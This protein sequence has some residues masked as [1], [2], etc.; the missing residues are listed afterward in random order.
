MKNNAFTLAE[1]LIVIGIIGV[2]A[3]LTL[4]NLNHATGDKEKVTK[5]KK[6]YSA[7]A[8]AV[9]RA[10][11]IYGDC[12]TWYNT[13]SN[14]VGEDFDGADYEEGIAKRITE[15][16]KVSKICGYEQGCWSD[17]LFL[18]QDGSSEDWA[19]ASH[20]GYG[21]LLSDGTSLAFTDNGII[22]IRVD[23][24]GP[25]KGKNQWGNDIFEFDICQEDGSCPSGLRVNDFGVGT[26]DCSGYPDAFSLCLLSYVTSWVIENGNLD[27][28]KADENGVCPNGVQLSWTQTSCH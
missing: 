27:Y 25:N 28:L 3:A 21:V 16:M 6:I 18:Y 19:L 1:T 24:D 9:D 11:V 17:G 7:L 13:L 22:R 15:F 20:G 2:V 26:T 8:D 12:D 23:I 14:Q 10:Q 5:V 4:P